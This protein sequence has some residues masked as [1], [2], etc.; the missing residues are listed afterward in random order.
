MVE[1]NLSYSS[2]KSSL[3][4]VNLNTHLFFCIF[5]L[6]SY[7][8]TV[9]CLIYEIIRIDYIFLKNNY[10]FNHYTACIYII[11]SIYNCIIIY[12]LSK[13]VF[14][15][16]KVLINIWFLLSCIIIFL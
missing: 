9:F 12:A 16:L 13:H 2:T 1:Y 10:L 14:C 4:N 15:E 11:K 6:F 8:K 5:N 3:E 7:R